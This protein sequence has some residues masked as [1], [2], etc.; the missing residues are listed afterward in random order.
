MDRFERRDFET[1]Q[2]AMADREH[3]LIDALVT[4]SSSLMSALSYIKST[5][6]CRKAAASNKIFDQTIKDY[7]TALEIARTAL[8]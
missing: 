6:E 5:P 1:K 4:V 3:K 2:R 7:E 8:R